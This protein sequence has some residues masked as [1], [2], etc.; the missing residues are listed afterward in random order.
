[1]KV[2]TIYKG[3]T[4]SSMVYLI[5]CY[6]R[7]KLYYR[8]ARL[9]RFPFRLRCF[10]ELL[11]CV[12]LTTGKD[13][14][15]DIFE[16]GS[17]KIGDNV[18]IND[19]CHIACASSIDIGNDTLIASRVFITDH[20]HDI[21]DIPSKT[22]LTCQDTVIGNRVWIGEGAVI[23]KGVSI[24]DDSIIAANATVTKSFCAGSIIGGNP[25]HTLRN[26]LK[27]K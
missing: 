8:S 6:I 2:R 10:G 17:L 20:D 13:C 5:Y 24:G 9:I 22:K 1:M 14:R 25:A 18:Q 26:K 16:N 19:F 12:G 3:Y 11:G 27:V 21:F 15:I 4:L 7:T 23:L